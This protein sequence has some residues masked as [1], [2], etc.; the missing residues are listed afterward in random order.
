[1]HYLG[2]KNR[3]KFYKGKN[4]LFFLLSIPLYIS[5]SFHFIPLMQLVQERIT[6]EQISHLSRSFG[7]S[8]IK[9]GKMLIAQTMSNASYELQQGHFNFV[10]GKSTNTNYSLQQSAGSAPIAPGTSSSSTNNLQSG[11][12][13]LGPT[14]VNQF[15][16]SISSQFIDFGILSAT[17]PVTRTQTI[18]VSDDAANYTVIGY[19]NNSP[20]VAGNGA[21]IPDTTCDAGSCTTIA[22]APWTNVLTYGFGYRCDNISSSPCTNDFSN[23]NYYKQFA[24]QAISATPQVIMSGTP[25]NNQVAQITY[26]VNISS[27]QPAG[28]YYNVITYVLTPAY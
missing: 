21:T 6:K 11:Y 23:G 20:L 10:N 5:S 18:T 13:F 25:G 9:E 19:E 22:A 14:T 15:S 2:I 7:I 28:D 16:L 4:I 3:E 8:D 26:K 12:W 1:M 27:T 17:N 24:N